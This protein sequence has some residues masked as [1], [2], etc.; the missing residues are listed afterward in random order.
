MP[1]LDVGLLGNI[2]GVQDSAPPAAVGFFDAFGGSADDPAVDST[3][4][5]QT[6]R[7]G[8]DTGVLAGKLV[9]DRVSPGVFGFFTA[10]AADIYENGTSDVFSFKCNPT[11]QA[12]HLIGLMA[13]HAGKTSTKIDNE[14][15]DTPDGYEVVLHDESW[16]ALSYV[17]R[18]VGGVGTKIGADFT[19]TG[20]VATTE[21]DVEIT[22]AAG[23][24]QV[25]FTIKV[26]G[27]T[28]ATRADNGASRIET[29]GYSGLAIKSDN[30]GN[31][32]AIDD[33]AIN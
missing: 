32:I 8:T 6:R 18:W 19:A 21:S 27:S 14:N 16:G 24:G 9:C 11:D 4:W 15:A 23:A 7:T 17:K 12:T 31:N 3:L 25:D 2:D 28:V 10:Y 5:T 22:I 13:R 20:L 29:A 30:S 1:F 26:D 33:F